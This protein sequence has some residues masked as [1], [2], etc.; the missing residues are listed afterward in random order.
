MAQ[1]ATPVLLTLEAYVADLSVPRSLAAGA[2]VS[3]SLLQFPALIIP[4]PAPPVTVTVTEAVGDAAVTASPT[5]AS[6]DAMTDVN[7]GAGKSCVLCLEDV[8][9]S[10]LQSA[11]ATVMLLQLDADVRGLAGMVGVGHVPVGSALLLLLTDAA[12]KHSVAKGRYLLHNLVGAVVGRVGVVLRFTRVD[13]ALVPHL[14]PQATHPSSSQPD[15]SAALPSLRRVS[16]NAMLEDAA[17]PAPSPQPPRGAAPVP[18]SA[19]VVAVPLAP[20]PVAVPTAAAVS[21]AATCYTATA[22]CRAAPHPVALPSS[23]LAHEL[24]L[25]AVHAMS[26]M[27]SSAAPANAPLLTQ[28]ASVLIDDEAEG[29]SCPPSL[30]Y[31]NTPCDSAC[32]R[33]SRQALSD[34]H[35]AP[36]HQERASAGVAPPF[37]GPPPLDI[38]GGRVG[39]SLDIMQ[40]VLSALP[41]DA[42]TRTKCVPQRGCAGACAGVRF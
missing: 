22:A 24:G 36:A 14:A 1:A 6:A 5:P 34:I 8:P 2:V 27:D 38:A 23:A 35:I 11:T 16:C 31:C 4:V 30:L 41:T 21:S 29:F 15:A 26:S 9:V 42:A 32:E 3:L 28:G 37:R 20:A 10:E 17:P 12:R 7:V 25:L 39:T 33:R 40:S 13:A 18:P 19:A